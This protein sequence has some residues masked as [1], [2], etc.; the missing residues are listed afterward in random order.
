VPTSQVGEFRF[1]GIPEA[2]RIYK[3][4]QDENLELYRQVVESQ[5]VPDE[6]TP[7]EASVPE[8]ALSTRLLY[9]L[10]QERALA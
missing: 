3:V 10:E 1:K 4:V 5:A 2:V 9:A 8:G 7:E 6:V